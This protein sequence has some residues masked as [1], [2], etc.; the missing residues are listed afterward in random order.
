MS[1]RKSAI[2]KAVRAKPPVPKMTVNK[3]NRF[4]VVRRRFRNTVQSLNLTAFY[5]YA[6]NIL[7]NPTFLLFYSLAIYLC[8][9]YSNSHSKSHIYKFTQNLVTSFPSLSTSAC[10]LYNAFVSLVPFLPVILSVPAR[11]RVATIVGTILYYNL[12]PE[13]SVYE[14][15]IHS[16]CIYLFIRTKNKYFRILS[17]SLL[18]ISYIMQ[19]A[20]PLPANSILVCNNSTFK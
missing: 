4:T 11:S 1:S 16:L 9:D 7:C 8:Y 13:R 6:V 14:Y 12:I 20:V 18:F 5:N 17:L 2:A 10:K 3:P 19:F 15:L